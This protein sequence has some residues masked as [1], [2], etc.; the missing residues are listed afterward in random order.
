MTAGFFMPGDPGQSQAV[1]VERVPEAA[2]DAGE[3]I[4]AF[5]SDDPGYANRDRR[6]LVG[7][8]A[9]SVIR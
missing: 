5:L 1:V 7:M 4:A 9:C 3:A 2:G 8:T 6:M